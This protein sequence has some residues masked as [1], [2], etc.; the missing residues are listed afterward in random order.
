ML[1]VCGSTID[2]HCVV[3]VSGFCCKIPFTAVTGNEFKSRR[4][5]LAQGGLLTGT[6][7]L[8]SKTIALPP[9]FDL[10]CIES[11]LTPGLLEEFSLDLFQGSILSPTLLLER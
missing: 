10:S 9:L 4:G 11:V 6:I 1:F 8:L 7:D 3:F 5:F 2:E